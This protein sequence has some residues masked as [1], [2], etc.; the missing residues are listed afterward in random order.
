MG[1]CLRVRRTAA[2][3]K[4]LGDERPKPRPHERA[5]V[6]AGRAHPTRHTRDRYDS[7]ECIDPLRETDAR[8][9]GSPCGPRLREELS[10]G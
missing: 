1:L 7:V 9:T 3:G 2:S 4:R 6:G 10:L 5:V 8:P